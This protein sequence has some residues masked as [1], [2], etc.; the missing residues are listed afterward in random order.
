MFWVDERLVAFADS[1]TQEGSTREKDEA[2][3]EAAA[4]VLSCW[5]KAEG[6]E[7][8]AMMTW[9]LLSSGPDRPAGQVQRGASNGLSGTTD[10]QCLE[11]LVTVPDDNTTYVLRMELV[12]K[13]R[14]KV[15]FDDVSVR[16]IQ[17]IELQT[18]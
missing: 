3:R 14:G 17:V 12:L 2:W 8:L 16:Q 18:P 1:V 5:A 15:W 11:A 9:Q 7:E 4:S 13:G 6:V 10:W